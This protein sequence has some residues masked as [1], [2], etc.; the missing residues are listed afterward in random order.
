M[1]LDRLTTLTLIPDP[2]SRA[3]LREILASVIYKGEFKFGRSNSDVMSTLQANRE[4]E[5]VFVGFSHG[6]E[7]IQEL[8][9]EIEVAGLR[10]H[11]AFIISFERENTKFSSTVIEMYMQGV[12]GFLKEPFSADDVRDLLLSVRDKL[13]RRKKDAAARAAKSVAYIASQAVPLIDEIWLRRIQGD[14][15]GGAA[16]KE[17]K[18]LSS[19]LGT[20]QRDYPEIY[21]QVLPGIFENVPVPESFEELK[22][23]QGTSKLVKPPGFFASELMEQRG[24]SRDRI[25]GIVRISPEDFDGILA[26]TVVLTEEYARE[27]SRALGKTA[28]EWMTMQR[29]YDQTKEQTKE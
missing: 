24:L 17:L 1:N 25:L 2:N 21:E 22:R 18:N 19:T 5:I 14:K 29:R 3:R 27:L 12:D 23:K 8:I 13:N 10:D 4:I 6:A 28:R 9:K 20:L 7:K 16:I 26:G 15:Q 11:H